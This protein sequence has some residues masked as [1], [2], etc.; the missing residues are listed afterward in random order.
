MIKEANTQAPEVCKIIYLRR[1]WPQ[2]NEAMKVSEHLVMVVQLV[3]GDAKP[4]T[5]YL[6]GAI[7][8]T[9]L[10]IQQNYEVPHRVLEG[11]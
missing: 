6:Y 11:Q 10:A 8:R 9:K 7:H 2:V 4:T 5:R 3:D 1:Y